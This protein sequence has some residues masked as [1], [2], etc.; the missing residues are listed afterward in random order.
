MLDLVADASPSCIEKQ[1]VSVIVK[2]GDPENEKLTD[3]LD[4][5]KRDVADCIME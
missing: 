5:P 2:K 4:I 1:K 3:P